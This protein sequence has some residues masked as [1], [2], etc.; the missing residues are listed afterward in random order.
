VNFAARQQFLR[1]IV[2]TNV[3]GFEAMDDSD[4]VVNLYGRLFASAVDNWITPDDHRV[5]SLHGNICT[6]ACSSC[7]KRIPLTSEIANRLIACTYPPCAACANQG[8]S[9]RSAFWRPDILFYNDCRQELDSERHDP[10]WTGEPPKKRKKDTPAEAT[11]AEATPA[12]AEKVDAASDSKYKA[13]IERYSCMMATGE[14][15]PVAKVVFVIGSSMLNKPLRRGLI[16]LSKRGAEVILVNPLEPTIARELE[17]VLW[18]KSTAKAFSECL[19]Q[20]L[21]EIA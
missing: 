14:R 17:R 11:P 19:L 1:G 20:S 6:I 9:S 15:G 8:R 5:A 18:I 4:L 21:L 2:T 12:E 16:S 10:S 3:D 13:N 7:W